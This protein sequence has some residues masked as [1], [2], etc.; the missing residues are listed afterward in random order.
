VWI[1][2]GAIVFAMLATVLGVLWLGN[3]NAVTTGAL[4]L[5]SAIIAVTFVASN[6][7]AGRVRL[8]IDPEGLHSRLF[9]REHTIRW[10]EIAYLTLRYVFLPGV[11][12]RIIYYS[13]RSPTRE[14]SF[15]SSM[16]NAHELQLAIEA[17]TGLKWPEPEIT[18][19]L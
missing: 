1:Q 15:P 3:W 6:W 5:S 2:V 8:R 14:F 12:G 16:R 19:T 13:V 4:A 9:Y 18:A 7:F 17:A 11:G 10:S